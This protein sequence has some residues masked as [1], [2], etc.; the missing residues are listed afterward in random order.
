M[1]GGIRSF[2]AAAGLAVAAT[3]D[4]ASTANRDGLD[5]ILAQGVLD[6]WRRKAQRRA[7]NAFK[8][9]QGGLSKYKPHQGKKERAKW[10]ARVAAGTDGHRY[11]GD[12]A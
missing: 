4:M 7:R 8:K 11:V 1:R 2:I 6:G 10:A 12:S 3:F 9:R 5:R